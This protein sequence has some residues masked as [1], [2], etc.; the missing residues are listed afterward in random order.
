VAL[1]GNGDLIT[2]IEGGSKEDQGA[3]DV[4]FTSLGNT[5]VGKNIGLDWEQKERELS[6]PQTRNSPRWGSNYYSGSEKITLFEKEL[7]DVEMTRLGNV[8]SCRVFLRKLLRSI[9][10]VPCRPVVEVL[11][12]NLRQEMMTVMLLHHY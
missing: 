10:K 5:K 9:I 1:V 2:G 12:I 3:R 4:V 6:Q 11:P 7:I 8:R